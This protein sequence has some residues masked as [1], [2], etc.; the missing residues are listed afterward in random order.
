MRGDI[1]ENSINTTGYQL[2]SSKK[3][4]EA[5]RIFQLN[6]ELHP[7][8][9]NVYDSLGEAYMN[10]G[11]KELAIQNYKK[12]LDLDPKNGNA[13]RD[14]EESCR[15]T[16]DRTCCLARATATS[17]PSCREFPSCPDSIL[18][19]RLRLLSDRRLRER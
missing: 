11:D 10:N 7:D 17:L 19:F 16:S 8:S 9:S 2:L 15:K 5:I 18:S 4:P 12:S 13:D 3:L 1:S 14:A 6:T